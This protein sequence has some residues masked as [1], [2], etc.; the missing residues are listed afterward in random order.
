MDLAYETGALSGDVT[1]IQ[2]WALAYYLVSKKRDADE[3]ADIER[4]WHAFFTNR[5]LYEQVFPQEP[6]EE[7]SAEL[8][9]SDFRDAE[10]MLAELDRKGELT[11]TENNAGEWI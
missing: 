8:V 7:Q 10:R 11:I 2:Y 6:E 3:R 9:E 5:K 4:R 1:P